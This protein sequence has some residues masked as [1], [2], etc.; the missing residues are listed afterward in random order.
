[1][2][3][4]SILRRYSKLVTL[5]LTDKFHFT[6]YLVRSV[7]LIR[8]SWLIIHRASESTIRRNVDYQLNFNP[9][10]YKYKRIMKM[11][12]NVML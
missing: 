5:S 2:Y 10:I 3:L 7:F 1:M 6:D 12:G 8:A 9:G 4:Y 11:R